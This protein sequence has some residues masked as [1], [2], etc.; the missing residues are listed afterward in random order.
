MKNVYSL[1][2]VVL[3]GVSSIVAQ[4]QSAPKQPEYPAKVVEKDGKTYVQKSLPLYLKFSTTPNGENY[5]LKSE[6]HPED[7]NPMYLDTEGINYIRSKWAVDPETG[8]TI[9]PQREVLMEIYA[10]GLAPRT[11]HRFSGAP[12]YR[13]GGVQ[14]FGKGLRFSLSANDGV[15]GVLETKYA[16]GGAYTNYSSEVSVPNEGAQMLYYYSADHVGNAESVRSSSFTVDVTAPTSSH[17]ID[18]VVYNGNIVNGSTVFRL[19]TTDNLSG[20]RRVNYAFDGGTDRLYSGVIRMSGLSDGDHT[21]EYEGTDNVDN[22]AGP[23]QFAFY[24]DLI[25]PTTDYVVGGDQHMAGGR[26]YVSPRTTLTLN[27]T[28]NKAGVK[29]IRYS[30]D[31]ASYQSYSSA[32]KFP[33]VLGTHSVRYRAEDNV[34]NTAS[35][36][37][38]SVYMDNRPPNT[39]IDYGSPQ[40]FSRGTL[41]ITSQTPVTL[42]ARDRESGVQSTVYGIDAAASNGYSQFTVPG[43]GQHTMH[44]KSTDN[45]NN[46][47]QEKT[48]QV[49][50]DNTPPDLYVNFSIDPIGQKDGLDIYPNYVRMFI[51]ATDEHT[52]TEAVFYS[53]DDGPMTRYSSPKTLDVSELSR[54]QK[55]KK[56]TVRVKCEDKLGNESEETF[57][58]YVGEGA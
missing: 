4:A 21:L 37:T 50:V 12:A 24:L 30:I 10:D 29:E 33:D 49:F 25:P 5:P 39:S 31:G 13:S 52:G 34:E 54:F 35:A 55:N 11:S 8:N 47:E 57:E 14:Y 6:D 18:G 46:E 41:Y 44:F 38:L 28:D 7:A 16:L 48:S 53:I 36:K 40:F 51:G 9:Y 2:L 19:S 58:F 17:S 56:Y 3:M 23:K 32:F 15:S 26:R 43:E 1:G 42:S 22:V 45:V 27:A 20:V